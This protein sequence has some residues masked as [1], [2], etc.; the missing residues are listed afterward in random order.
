M[1]SDET[2]KNRRGM[3]DLLSL[4]EASCGRSR[5]ASSYRSGLQL[6]P[7]QCPKPLGV[8]RVA[9]CDLESCVETIYDERRPYRLQTS[10]AGQTLVCELSS[11]LSAGLYTPL[12]SVHLR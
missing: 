6:C 7:C 10:G 8:E 9:H 1:P 11:L 5:D 3:C 4:V 2:L 12:H